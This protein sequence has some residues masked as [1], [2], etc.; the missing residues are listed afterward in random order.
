MRVSIHSGQTKTSMEA[1]Q[2]WSSV[3]LWT[4]IVQS[5]IQIILVGLTFDFG[6]LVIKDWS[7]WWSDYIFIL[8]HNKLKNMAHENEWMAPLFSPAQ[9]TPLL[10]GLLAPRWSGHCYHLV[11]FW[12]SEFQALPQISIWPCTLIR[13]S[14]ICVFNKP[15][16]KLVA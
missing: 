15:H 5:L 8:T 1:F 6:D 2:R 7:P 4:I 11:A 10:Q 12:S 13:S 14:V 16:K 9:G 3:T